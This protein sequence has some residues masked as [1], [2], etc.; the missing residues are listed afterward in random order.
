MPMQPDVYGTVTYVKVKP[1]PAL[2]IK[3]RDPRTGETKEELFP[4]K[5]EFTAL[6]YI[7]G[8]QVGISLVGVRFLP[9]SVAQWMLSEEM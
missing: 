5:K 7:E 3:F 2:Q 6:K 4:C 9:K 8:D 1:F